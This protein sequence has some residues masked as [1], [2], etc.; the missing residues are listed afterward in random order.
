MIA[1]HFSYSLLTMEHRKR[2]FFLVVGV[3]ILLAIIVT[4]PLVLRKK[5]DAFLS[6][7]VWTH[8]SNGSSSL[9]W[10]LKV[11]TCATLLQFSHLPNV[12]VTCTVYSEERVV[13]RIT[14]EDKPCCQDGEDDEEVLV[15]RSGQ[16]NRQLSL[17]PGNYLILPGRDRSILQYRCLVSLEREVITRYWTDD[18]QFSFSL[19]QERFKVP[20]F[21]AKTT[22]SSWMSVE[23]AKDYTAMYRSAVIPSI[24]LLRNV[25]RVNT[26]EVLYSN[27]GM[28]MH[29]LIID[30]DFGHSSEHR[31]NFLDDGSWT[32]VHSP[33]YFEIVKNSTV[34]KG[35][36]VSPQPVLK[37][38]TRETFEEVK[39]KLSKKGGQYKEAFDRMIEKIRKA[40]VPPP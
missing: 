36:L 40:G 14:I 8:I 24:I 25:S 1:R 12:T 32:M 33:G 37:E 22:T 16:G 4:L 28:A 13:T 39:K 35:Q 21:E 3:V 27:G 23:R 20:T 18:E 9:P 19:R 17:P 7:E 30:V 10:S 26:T 38:W 29:S 5:R 15:G 34:S 31:K 11:Q 2:N 6:R